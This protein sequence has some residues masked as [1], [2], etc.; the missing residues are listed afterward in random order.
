M[1]IT[2][3]CMSPMMIRFIGAASL[4]G[5]GVTYQF[6]T[7]PE[8]GP[9]SFFYSN[10]Y[11]DFFRISSRARRANSESL[12][13]QIGIETKKIGFTYQLDISQYYFDDPAI[14]EYWD[15][16]RIQQTSAGSIFDPL[17]APILGNIAAVNNDEL[18]VNGIFWAASK[19]DTRLPIGRGDVPGVIPDFFTDRPCWEFPFTSEEQPEYYPNFDEFGGWKIPKEQ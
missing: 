12:I 3:M 2:G 8:G 6:E 5:G 9:T 7:G 14:Y 17:P 19:Q 4:H 13:A 15:L 1:T 11:D 18:P 10:E 16:I